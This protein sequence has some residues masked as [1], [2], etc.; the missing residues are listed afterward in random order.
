MK[1]LCSLAT[2]KEVLGATKTGCPARIGRAT[3]LNIPSITFANLVGTQLVS[4]TVTN[5]AALGETYTVTIKNPS[6]F[7]VT[8][9]PAVFVIGVGHRNK[10]TVVFTVRATKASQASSFGMITMT[11]SLGHV[12]RVPVSVVN[13]LLK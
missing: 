11:G 5:V 3:D 1:F 9:N 13:K 12:V 6:D 7:V 4:R 10:Q 8:A 2:T